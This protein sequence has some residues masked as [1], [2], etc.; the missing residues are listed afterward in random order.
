MIPRSV[1][2][3]SGSRRR[4][5][6]GGRVDRERHVAGGGGS[7]RGGAELRLAVVQLVLEVDVV[8]GLVHEEVQA[9]LEVPAVGG[10]H[11]RVAGGDLRSRERARIAVGRLEEVV[12]DVGREVAEAHAEVRRHA[13]PGVR[14]AGA[15]AA[16]GRGALGDQLGVVPERNVEVDAGRDQLLVGE[17]VE[18]VA[19]HLR[20]VVGGEV[21]A[22]DGI[23]SPAVGAAVV[24]AAFLGADDG[25]VQESA[26][27]R[28][29]G[30]VDARA[31][32]AR[33]AGGGDGIVAFPDAVSRNAWS[34]LPGMRTVSVCWSAVM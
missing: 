19:D 14:R 21:D 32:H 27:G 22:E 7:D 12:G 11:G 25:E 30:R 3:T 29:A 34:G 4:N 1:P 28:G 18:D 24:V 8:L 2:P 9:H 15:V 20:L 31:R 33:R 23:L 10:V 5:S 6:S 26:E 13:R 17:A 16:E